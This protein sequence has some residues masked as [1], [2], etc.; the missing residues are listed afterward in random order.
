MP[1]QNAATRLLAFV[2]RAP[3]LDAGQSAVDALFDL[4][5]LGALPAPPG[6]ALQALPCLTALQD[7]AARVERALT[8]AGVPAELWQPALKRLRE[9]LTPNLL[10]GPWQPLLAP[11]D[12]TLSHSLQWAAHVLPA[13]EADVPAGSIDALQFA[14]EEVLMLIEQVD[15]PEALRDWLTQRMGA[16]RRA[17]RV[18]PLTGLQPLREAITQTAGDLALRRAQLVPDATDLAA[19]AGPTCR[20]ASA[21]LAQDRKSVV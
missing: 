15:L 6:A 9:G 11:L 18:A 5:G 2:Q 20:Q 3:S 14:I 21:A 12:A 1:G 7:Q 13:D 17:L 8:A 19:K 10:S 4:F 16:L